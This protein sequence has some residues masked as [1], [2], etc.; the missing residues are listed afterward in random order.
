MNFR[1]MM[2]GRGAFIGLLALTAAAPGCLFAPDACTDLLQCGG[3]GGT[4]GSQWTSK[5][6]GRT[7]RKA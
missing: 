6:T 1:N 3:N 5:T 7:A 4:F 2:F